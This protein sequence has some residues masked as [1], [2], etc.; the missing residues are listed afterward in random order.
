MEQRGAPVGFG[1][2]DRGSDASGRDLAD[3]AEELRGELS[4]LRVVDLE[5]LLGGLDQ[6]AS[7]DADPERRRCSRS[8]RI[9]A[10]RASGATPRRYVN[11][12]PVISAVSTEPFRRRCPVEHRLA[13]PV[14]FSR[15]GDDRRA[16]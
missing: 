16:A 5:C 13:I 10:A 3:L 12:T 15:R 1:A 4:A 11:F 6:R 7:D 8:W 14:E 2:I 9:S